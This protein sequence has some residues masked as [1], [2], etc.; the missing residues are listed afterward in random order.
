M[1]IQTEKTL[2]VIDDEIAIREGLSFAFKRKGFRVLLAENGR[3]GLEIVRTTKVDFVISD[4][5]MAGGDG[6][7]FLTEVRKMNFKLPCVILVSGFT[8]FT[9]EDALKLGA[10]A[11][12]S[13][14]FNLR[15]LLTQVMETLG[16]SQ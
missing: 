9:E 8:D 10:V 6:I 11:M 13:K 5:R 7:E 14:P 4:V 2:L 15:L 16:N 3:Q 12:Y 1:E